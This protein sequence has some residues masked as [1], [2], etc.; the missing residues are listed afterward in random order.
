MQGNIVEENVPG[1]VKRVAAAGSPVYVV[2]ESGPAN[3]A[4]NFIQRIVAFFRN[5]FRVIANGFTGW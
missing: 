1:G 4:L 5:L 3:I 2:C